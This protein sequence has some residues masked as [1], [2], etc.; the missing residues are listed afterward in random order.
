MKKIITFGKAYLEAFIWL[1]ALV[2]LAFMDPYSTQPSLCV[3]HHLG[4]ESCPGCGLGHSIS[5][6]FHGK[7][8]LSFVT[9]PL[10]ILTIVFLSA[11]II[12]I[13]IQNY[14]YQQ[15]NKKPKDEISRIEV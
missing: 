4:I 12:M 13:I 1:V 2:L 11:R 10:G 3:F 7:F 14:K 5:A 9:H 8:V 15:F 6:A